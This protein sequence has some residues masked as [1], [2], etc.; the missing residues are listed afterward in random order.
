VKVKVADTRE[1]ETG[2]QLK[3]STAILKIP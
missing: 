2:Y 3:S 1:H